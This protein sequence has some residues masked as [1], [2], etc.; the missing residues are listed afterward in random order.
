MVMEKNHVDPPAYDPN[1]PTSEK[2]WR[3][4]SQAYAEQASGEVWAVIGQDLRVGNIWE[5]LEFLV[6]QVNP[7]VTKVTLIDPYTLE[8]KVLLDRTN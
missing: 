7:N 8:E 3:D 4:I 5:R 2:N 1:D 6:L